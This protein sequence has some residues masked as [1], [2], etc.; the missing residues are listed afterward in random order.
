MELST[1]TN[2]CAFQRGRERL[3]VEFSIRACAEAGYQVLDINFCMAMNP[4]SPLREDGWEDYVR[5]IGKLAQSLGIRFNQSHLP[6]YDVEKDKGT[7]K[8]AV[9]EELIR[10]SIR[11]TA[12][13]GARWAVT[14]PFT[15]Y[16]AGHDARVSRQANL[17]YYAVHVDL[18]RQ[19]GIGIALENDFEYF[20]APKQRIYC[21]SVYELIDLC[22]AF[23]DPDHVGV[24]YDFGHAN[25]TGGFHRQNLNAIGRRLKAIHVQD[26][27]G[28]T[29]EHLLPFFGSIDWNDAMRGL[30]E[31]GYNGDLTFEIQEFGRFLP[32][33]LKY[34]AVQDSLIVG[35]RLMALYQQAKQNPQGAS[36]AP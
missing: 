7:E 23:D 9:M 26:N 25:L 32:K 16:G 4:F 10:R 15:V 29:D 27:H 14:H 30:A 28:Q 13:L 22:D 12:M 31:S 1:S 35:Q 19:N 11:G 5:S 8:A 36:S 17:D 34:L 18:A 6:Y 3:P 33:D 2:I 24:C 21:A 20:S